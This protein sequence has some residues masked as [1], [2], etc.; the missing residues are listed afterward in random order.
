[1]A[2]RKHFHLVHINASKCRTMQ[3]PNIFPVFNIIFIGNLMSVIIN[4]AMLNVV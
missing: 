4:K 1:M 2:L 3:L